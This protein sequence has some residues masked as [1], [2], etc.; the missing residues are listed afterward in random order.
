MVL[1][2]H[3]D[4][5][6]AQRQQANLRILMSG[7]SGSGKTMSSLVLARELLNGDVGRRSDGRA[8]IADIDSERGSATLYSDAVPFDTLALD[9]TRPQDYVDAIAAA[10]RA[11][12]PVLII[13]S[14]S[15]A[16]TTALEMVDLGGGWIKAGKTVTPLLRRL[17]DTMLGYPGHVIATARAKTETAVVRN[18]DGKNTIQ[19]LGLASVLRE[20]TE[21]EFSVVL[22]LTAD[23]TFVVSKSRCPAVSGVHERNAGIPETARVLQAWLGSGAKMSVIDELRAAIANASDLAELDA[24]RPRIAAAK[25]SGENTA[26]LQVPYTARKAVLTDGFPE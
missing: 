4:F 1:A 12:Y 17:I 14:L 18:A 23:G 9:R 7:P 11:E 26:S 22:D 10:R 24:L 15:H 5:V 20:G 21:Y 8:Q 6:P 19:K 13:D 3:M 2:A 16:W 25:E